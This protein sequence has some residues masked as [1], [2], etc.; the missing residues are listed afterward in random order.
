M[1]SPLILAHDIGTSGTRT[2][3]VGRDGAILASM[4]APHPTH[5]GAGGVAEQDP[6]DWWSGVCHN[7]RALAER[8][9]E[10][11]RRIVG[12]GLSGQMLACLPVDAGGE[13]LRRS[14]IHSDAR[15]VRQAELIAETVG[16]DDVYRTTGNVLDPR[17]PLAKMLWLKDNEPDV[18]RRASRFL[19]SKD[20]VA[21][22]M[23]GS[24]DSTDLSD[25]THAQW[26]DIRRRQ[27]A[28]DLLAALGLDA[29]K[30][31]ALHRS[32]DVVGKLCKAAAQAMG[33]PSGIPVVAGAGDGCC[34]TVGAGAVRPGDTYCCLGT[35]AWIASVAEGPFIDPKRRVF[36][37]LS[38][39]GES[40]GVFGTV[41]SAG[42]SLEWV[43]DLLGEADFGAFDALLAAAPAGCDGLIF[44]PYLEGERSPIYDANARGVF[45]GI[46]PTHG[47][48]HFVR[49]VVEGV[50]FALR[51]VLEVMRET[52]DVP[53]LRLIGGGGQSA[54]WQQ[55]LADICDAEIRVLSTQAA[56]ATSLG[57]AVA[58]GVGVGLFESV[59]DGCRGI[60]VELTR[61]PTP[62]LRQVYARSF[63]I[64]ASLY[65]ALKDAFARL[66]ES[67]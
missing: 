34:A 35:T 23:T 59:A 13:P 47:K 10:E 9:P 50:S 62:E 36:N 11:S 15:A 17:S 46:G 20:F 40:C 29:G 2:S 57:A 30:L 65:P 63:A 27:Y 43:M 41:Q 21:G 26:L 14:M 38:M 42:R 55:M 60:R 67:A 54:A 5:Y 8:H 12:I 16:R 7:T 25:A 37:I 53:A 24:F 31:P 6:E 49:S 33:L 18:Y 52:A 61:P 28:G 51:S 3:I 19:Q 1:D 45:F 22:R 39:D 58:A 32:T 64:Y 66:S 48:A 56:D 44:L 4:S